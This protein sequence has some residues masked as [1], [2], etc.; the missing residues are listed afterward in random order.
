MLLQ[1][2]RCR[3]HFH[4]MQKPLRLPRKGVLVPQKEIVI[5]FLCV[6]H[7]RLYTAT[8]VCTNYR[9]TVAKF[10]HMSSIQDELTKYPSQKLFGS[11]QK[12]LLFHNSSNRKQLCVEDSYGTRSTANA[13][14]EVM[15]LERVCCI[16]HAHC[17][18]EIHLSDFVCNSSATITVTAI[19]L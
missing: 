18:L 4:Q 7:F 5:H 1:I 3:V 15:S 13:F 10:G 19:T 9:K 2:L 14:Y 16:S 6:G 11:I 12:N 8:D 17:I